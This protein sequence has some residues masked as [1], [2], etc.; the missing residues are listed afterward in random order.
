M[1]SQWPLK[2]IA[3]APRNVQFGDTL[4][5]A[6]ALGFC[7]ARTN[8]SHHILIDPAIPEPLSL[9]NVRGQAKPYQ[10]RPML[11]VVERY[12]LHLDD[13]VKDYH[14][15]IAYSDAL[16]E[17]LKANRAWLKAARAAAFRAGHLSGGLSG[18]RRQ[19]TMEGR[20]ESGRL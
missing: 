14:I 7:P 19:P 11:Q 8:G 12:N 3:T 6:Q 9:Q 16:A 2:L 5:L 1:R 13:E 15:N 10:V 4:T 20:N 17:V 18:A